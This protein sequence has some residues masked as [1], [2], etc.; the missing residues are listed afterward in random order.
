MAAVLKPGEPV[1][2]PGLT[3]SM[4]LAKRAY[5]AGLDAGR[6]EGALVYFNSL[7]MEQ[8]ATDMKILKALNESLQ[9]ALLEAIKDRDFW[10]AK[11]KDCVHV[12]GNPRR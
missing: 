9:E 2:R 12:I 4:Q 6:K 5:R 8:I 3:P 1:T 7:T 10:H 11:F